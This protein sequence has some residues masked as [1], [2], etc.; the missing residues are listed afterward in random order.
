MSH[1]HLERLVGTIINTAGKL[2][3]VR[4]AEGK[5]EFWWLC[6]LENG[7]CNFWSWPLVVLV[8]AGVRYFCNDMAIRWWTIL[9]II[10][11]F[12]LVLL[13]CKVGHFS[14]FSID[15]TLFSLLLNDKEFCFS[16]ICLNSIFSTLPQSE[17]TSLA[18][19]IPRMQWVHL[20]WG[21]F[22]LM[23]IFVYCLFGVSTLSN[24]RRD[25]ISSRPIK[26]Q[27][28]VKILK[29]SNFFQKFHI[30]FQNFQNNKIKK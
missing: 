28:K 4:I 30:K 18:V 24:Q 17:Y 12:V 8:V 25:F 9:Y 27:K 15:V 3:H 1:V 10:T 23:S 22:E 7:I 20:T 21:I 26:L 16:L 13:C 29:I 19:S 11:I 14:S 6:I 5:Y 2:F